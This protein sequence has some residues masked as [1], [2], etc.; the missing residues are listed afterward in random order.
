MVWGVVLLDLPRRALG[1]GLGLRAVAKGTSKHRG[2][3]S[4]QMKAEE[5]V[6]RE[7]GTGRWE[8]R[9]GAGFPPCGGRRQP[10]SRGGRAHPSLIPG[11]PDVLWWPYRSLSCGQLPD[12]S[13][14]AL[15]SYP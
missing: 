1:E 13:V 5:V 7:P 12:W 8:R 14:S 15:E 4:Q 11:C 2:D 3:G 10:G 9:L 6:W